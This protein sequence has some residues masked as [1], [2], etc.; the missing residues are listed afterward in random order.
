[1]L[2]LVLQE[3]KKREH[4]RLIVRYRHHDLLAMRFPDTDNISHR[5]AGDANVKNDAR[6]GF[7]A[8][9]FPTSWFF[10]DLPYTVQDFL[11]HIAFGLE[12]GERLTGQAL[13]S[14]ATL[15][16]IAASLRSLARCVTD[17]DDHL[18][19]LEERLCYRPCLREDGHQFT[20]RF[21]RI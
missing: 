5:F 10:F 2:L 7:N 4:Y 20:I 15:P 11:P 1:M 8:F 19:C 3:T 9:P 17:L 18:P 16:V 21:S 14:F 13:D 6:L 12:F